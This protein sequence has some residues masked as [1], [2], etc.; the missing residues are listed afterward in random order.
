M[1][2]TIILMCALLLPIPLSHA[3]SIT[4]KGKDKEK[5]A[6][7]AKKDETNKLVDHVNKAWK[8]STTKL[9]KDKKLH[10]QQLAQAAIQL[11]E[12]AQILTHK[13][14]IDSTFNKKEIKKIQL[15]MGDIINFITESLD[16]DSKAETARI[17]AE[18]KIAEEAEP[19]T[20]EVE[21]EAS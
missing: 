18:E 13:G 7:Q 1:K 17:E 14:I 3:W 15:H 12:A 9:A 16:E 20:E 19:A 5:A 21:E 11:A 4:Q 6:A 8:F 2:K 10:V